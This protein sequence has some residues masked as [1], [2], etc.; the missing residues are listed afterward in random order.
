[1]IH[2]QR[3]YQ[4][5]AIVILFVKKRIIKLLIILIEVISNLNDDDFI[6]ESTLKQRKLSGKT[7]YETCT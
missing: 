2:L 1:M 7:L 5:E 6:C 3:H 4:M